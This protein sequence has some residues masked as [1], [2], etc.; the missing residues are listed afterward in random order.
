M[1]VRLVMRIG[2]NRIRPAT[3]KAS[4][5]GRPSWR[6]WPMYSISR[7][8]FLTSKPMSRMAPMNDETLSGVPV[9]QRA[10]SALASEIGC[11]RKINKGNVRLLN[12]RA[13]QQKHEGR[14]DDQHA[15]QAGKRFLLRAI[16]AGQLPAIAGRKM[17]LSELRCQSRVG[18]LLNC[19]SA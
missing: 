18:S 4:C 9:I 1:A 8:P 11:A 5:S 6:S 19:R 10:N 14:R 16:G 2:R 7:M 3:S 12:C 15:E 17:D 13:E